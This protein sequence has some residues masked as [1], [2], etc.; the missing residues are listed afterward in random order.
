MDEGT[1]RIW[2]KADKIP[3]YN[4]DQVRNDPCGTRIVKQDYGNRS[5]KY[6][7]EIDHKDPKGGD[8]IPNLQPLN[9]KNNAKKSDGKLDCGCSS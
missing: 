6:G 2:K 5:S 8:Q 1:E 9:W 3:G 4:P 7:W